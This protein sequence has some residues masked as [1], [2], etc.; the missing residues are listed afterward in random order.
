ML[1]LYK[2]FKSFTDEDAKR[3]EALLSESDRVDI[4]EEKSMEF[5][6]SAADILHTDLDS[7]FLNISSLETIIV[8]IYEECGGKE[9]RAYLDSISDIFRSTPSDFADD[10]Y[11]AVSRDLDFLFM[12]LSEKASINLAH[13]YDTGSFS[14][15]SDE[16]LE[17][18][19]RE[20]FS[21][22][23]SEILYNSISDSSKVSFGRR[24][25]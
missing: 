11:S 18:R 5:I 19:Y 8:S 22:F 25:R 7:A 4:S 12:V 2:N 24:G 1:H 14:G 16:L 3:V 20:R 23:S 9:A 6:K 17:E 15:I 21:K 10:A 13:Y